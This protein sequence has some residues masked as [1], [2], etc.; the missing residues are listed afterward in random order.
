MV[1]LSIKNPA[2]RAVTEMKPDR[3]TNG[4]RLGGLCAE[5]RPSGAENS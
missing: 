5:A 3:R 4:R 2:A 1:K